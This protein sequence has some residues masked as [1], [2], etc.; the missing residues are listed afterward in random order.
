MKFRNPSTP[1]S[2]ATTTE[3][4]LCQCS[5]CVLA[6][7]HAIVWWSRYYNFVSHNMLITNIDF[8]RL[9]FCSFVSHNMLSGKILQSQPNS[10]QQNIQIT[11]IFF[12]LLFANL[13][14]DFV[15]CHLLE[16]SSCR[17]TNSSSRAWTWL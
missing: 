16:S 5:N 4:I 12:I 2:S 15:K 3:K 9:F 10:S 14:S 11:N 6:S 1:A 17:G 13:T 8:I 7:W